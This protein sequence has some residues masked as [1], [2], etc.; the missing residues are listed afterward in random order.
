MKAGGFIAA[1]FALAVV[2]GV[3]AMMLNNPNSTTQLFAAGADTITGIT[4]GLE[5]KN[6]GTAPNG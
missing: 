6:A 3:L 1:L 2:V 5:G 4:H